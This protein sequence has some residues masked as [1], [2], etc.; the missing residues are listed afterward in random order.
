MLKNKPLSDANEKEVRKF[1]IATYKEVGILNLQIDS[2]IS[3]INTDIRDIEA[4]GFYDK[5]FN[6]SKN[7]SVLVYKNRNFEVHVNIEKKIS[8]YQDFKR[9]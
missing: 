5:R 3:A 2:V 8:T 1:L 9:K 4:K 6:V 7:I